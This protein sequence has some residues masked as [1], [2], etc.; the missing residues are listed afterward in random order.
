MLR[1]LARVGG[2]SGLRYAS[3]TVYG[4]M[5]SCH[6]PLGTRIYR[7]D[8]DTTVP[9]PFDL[10]ESRDF[11][12]FP[13]ITKNSIKM[14]CLFGAREAALDHSLPESSVEAVEQCARM[15]SVGIFFCHFSLIMCADLRALFSKFLHSL[16][17]NST[18]HFSEF[19]TSALTA[20]LTALPQ[21]V[22]SLQPA[23]M[24]TTEVWVCCIR[25]D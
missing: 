20:E 18:H 19:C 17:R 5:Q 6:A 21:S 3:S 22:D 8:S 1:V 12:N 10:A 25:S 15:P 16:D 11:D 24:Q 2:F 14:Y 13:L 7:L 4:R 9:V 23:G